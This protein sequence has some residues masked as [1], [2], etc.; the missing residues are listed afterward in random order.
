MRYAASFAYMLNHQFSQFSSVQSLD[1][2][3]RRGNTTDDSAE[4]VFQS[5]LQEAFMS[6]SGMGRDIHP[7]DIV[8][9]AFLAHHKR[10]MKRK[11]TFL[12]CS[13]ALRDSAYSLSLGVSLSPLN[14][15]TI[16]AN[17]YF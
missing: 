13:F 10:D 14:I 3:G 6:K 15:Y 17:T 12:L 4:I 11:C 16:L 7:F 5:F 2:L 1:R 9:P 8:H